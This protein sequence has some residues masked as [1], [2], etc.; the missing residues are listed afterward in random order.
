MI[1]LA[2][3]TPMGDKKNSEFFEE[4]LPRVY[5]RRQESGLEQIVGD[6]AGLAIQVEHGDAIDYMAELA[7]MGPY[8]FQTARITDTHKIYVLQSQPDFPRLFLLE[9]LTAALRGLDHPLE[10][11]VPDVA[12]EAERTLHRRDLRCHLGEGRS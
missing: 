6:M 9:P 5:Q 12:Q 10:H 8:R 1:D 11:D 7:V 2:T 4:F 3:Y